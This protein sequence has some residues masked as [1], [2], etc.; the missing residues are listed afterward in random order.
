MVPT[1]YP[2]GLAGLSAEEYVTRKTVFEVL[3]QLESMLTMLNG[4]DRVWNAPRNGI[5]AKIVAAKAAGETVAGYDPDDLARLSQ[6]M[7]A[8]KTFLAT[9]I[10]I[11]LADGSTEMA[12]PESVLLT[13]YV[14]IA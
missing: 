6:T 12:T 11:T 5:P 1:V 2:N 9:E 14:P 4:L 3:P 13:R 8:L 7:Q 10:E